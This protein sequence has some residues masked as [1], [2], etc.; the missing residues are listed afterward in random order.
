[1]NQ[2][3][4]TDIANLR[5]DHEQTVRPK[6]DPM[7]AVDWRQSAEMLR[8]GELY[9]KKVPVIDIC[10]QLGLNNTEFLR[11]M[12]R[13][14]VAWRR[15]GQ[16]DA[17]QRVAEELAQLDRLQAMYEDAWERSKGKVTKTHR[18]IVPAKDNTKRPNPPSN[19][20]FM[21]QSVHDP[22]GD[23]PDGEEIPVEQKY[24]ISEM[25]EDTEVQVGDARF[26]D[27]MLKC[28]DRRVKLLGLDSPEKMMVALSDQRGSNPG[29]TPMEVRLEKYRGVLVA[30]VGG[31]KDGNPGQHDPGQPLDT[32][33]P[34]SEASGVL[35]VPGRIR[36]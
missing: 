27:G 15:Q 28:I 24:V 6:G 25:T 30:V 26:L 31:A 2:D 17:M 19:L 12:D 18:K 29:N 35:D 21:R 16:F 7:D 32:E 33:R 23:I 13:I 20:R 14:S 5:R 3:H 22:V 9:L 10:R 36:E 4:V 1:M 11:I 8:V 34:A